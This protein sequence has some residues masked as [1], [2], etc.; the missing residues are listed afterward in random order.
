MIMAGVH[1]YSAR[2]MAELKAGIDEVTASW[3]PRAIAISD[4][5]VNTANLRII[6]LQHAFVTDADRKQ[7]LAGMMISLLDEISENRDIYETLMASSEKRMLYSEN[8]RTMY[9][10]FD[11]QW[12]QYQDLT[13]TIL[14]LIRDN[15][16]DAAVALLNGEAQDVFDELSTDLNKL[17]S[18]NKQ[19]SSDAAEQADQTYQSAHNIMISLYIFTILL[20]CLYCSRFGPVHYRPCATTGTGGRRGGQERSRRA[21]GYAGQG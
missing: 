6:Q 2:T 16:Q 11:Q 5:N 15:E 12:D 4:L 10:E 17:V 3:L 19:E 20:V 18:I 14:Q 7:T 8:E 9:A 1:S 21:T 13:L